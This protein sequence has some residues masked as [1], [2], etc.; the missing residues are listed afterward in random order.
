MAS[1][2]LASLLNFNGKRGINLGPP[3][4]DND[5]AR[6][7]DVDDSYTAAISRANHTGTQT[8]STISDFDT[9]VRTNRLDQMA[10]PTN[11]V[12]FSSQRAVNVADPEGAQDAATKAWVEEKLAGLSGGQFQKGVVAVSTDQNVNL[13]SP[14]ATIDGVSLE[15]GDRVLL[16]GQ[17]TS[18]QNG[19]YVW[20]GPEL[21][22]TRAPNWDTI[23]EAVVGSYW[24]VAKGTRADNFALM[25][26][27][28][29]TLGT[30][31]LAVGHIA[32]VPAAGKPLEADLGDGAATSF[33]LTHNFNTKAVIVTVFRNA[34][35]W[36]EIDV[37]ISRPNANQVTI[38]PDDVWSSNQFHV[39]VSK[40]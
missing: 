32:I 13:A 7:I 26:N 16:F 3:Q 29:F 23:A 6:K 25:T 2:L 37:Y 27:D 4:N 28:S 9:A 36:D 30:D 1:R 40:A 19:P 22:M 11:P 31:T 35:P 8:A 15:V 20:N 12:N 38:E 33:T 18:T 14:G 5:T 34:S 10:N 24:I 21:S 39:V 17:S